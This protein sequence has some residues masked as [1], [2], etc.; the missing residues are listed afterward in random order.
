ME[1]IKE[2]IYINGKLENEI[3][4][5]YKSLLKELLHCELYKNMKI[6]KN[7]KYDNNG[8]K[9][10]TITFYEKSNNVK[11]VYENISLND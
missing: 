5:S 3:D 6:R 4:K 2:K 10:V 11:Y 9:I 1:T 7:Y 8:N